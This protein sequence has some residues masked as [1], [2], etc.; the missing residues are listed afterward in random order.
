MQGVPRGSH[1]IGRNPMPSPLEEIG[2]FP[3]LSC[4]H[5]I[6]RGDGS[7]W[8]A[9][10]CSPVL[11]HLLGGVDASH[12]AQRNLLCGGEGGKPN[13][14]MNTKQLS[15]GPQGVTE[16]S[17]PSS[18]QPPSSVFSANH[19]QRQ[20]LTLLLLFSAVK[21]QREGVWHVRPPSLCPAVLPLAVSQGFSSP[22]TTSRPRQPCRR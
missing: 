8:P 14:R 10:G 1:R 22:S 16:P 5:R 12:T 3:V 21:R 15:N 2:S 18:P 20:P 7:L 19:R 6:F 4:R 11:F 13:D 17:L 9:F